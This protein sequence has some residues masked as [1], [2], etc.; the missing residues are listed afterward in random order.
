R[1][2]RRLR[3][4]AVFLEAVVPPGAIAVEP[5]VAGLPR[6]AVLPTQLG[7]VGVRFPRLLNEREFRTHCSELLPRHSTGIPVSDVLA[8]LRQGSCRLPA[9]RTFGGEEATTT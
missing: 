6:D 7:D 3:A 8:P 1:Q 9:N 5:F 4:P 2:G